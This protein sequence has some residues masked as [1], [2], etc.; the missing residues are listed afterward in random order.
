MA[1]FDETLFVLA[2]SAGHKS[3]CVPRSFTPPGITPG[4]AIKKL[5]TERVEGLKPVLISNKCI[6]LVRCERRH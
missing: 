3:G 4:S 6:N 1:I 2:N 5:K